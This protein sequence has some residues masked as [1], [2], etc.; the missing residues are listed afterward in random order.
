MGACKCLFGWVLCLSI[1]IAGGI[2]LWQFGPWKDSASES[3]TKSSA[4]DLKAA[5]NT[6]CDGCCNGLAS[7]C[8]RPVNEVSFA[9]VHNAMSSRD[10][11]FGGYNNLLGLEDALVKGYRGL[12]LDSCICDGSLGETLQGFIKGEDDKGDNYHGLCHTSCDAGVRDPSVVFGN[13]KTFLDVNPREVMIIEFEV[14]DNSLAEL[15]TAIDDSELDTYVLTEKGGES[16]PTIQQMIDSNKRLLLFAH[17]DGIESCYIEGATCPEGI[18]YTFDHF[19]QTN[20]N[21]ETCDIKGVPR[22]EPMDFFLMNHWL[23]NDADLPSQENAERFNTYN[24]LV[25]RYRKC[26]DRIPNVIATEFWSVGDTLEFVFDLN[27]KS[28]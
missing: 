27:Q 6:I 21:D 10:N 1:L 7:N 4:E 3:D 8:N 9:M 16:W 24:S 23:N 15:H 22:A 11:L 12:M 14:N 2:C 18:F 20:W 25:E 5:S 17:G 19:E 26:G 28:V 13:I